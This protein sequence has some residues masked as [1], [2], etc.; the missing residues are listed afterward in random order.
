MHA[1]FPLTDCPDAMSNICL[2]SKLQCHCIQ[3]CA[4]PPDGYDP[5]ARQDM[6]IEVS[7]FPR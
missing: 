6:Q 3:G 2:A 7:V 1:G 5:H 4:V